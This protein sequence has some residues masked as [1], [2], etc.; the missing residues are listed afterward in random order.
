MVSNETLEYTSIDRKNKETYTSDNFATEFVILFYSRRMI[1][2]VW[3]EIWH[4]FESV[5]VSEVDFNP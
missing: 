1:E 5:S 4:E 3:T 2:S